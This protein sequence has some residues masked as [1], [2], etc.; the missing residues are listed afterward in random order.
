[1]EALDVLEGQHMWGMTKSVPLKSRSN[2]LL[3][4]YIT[5]IES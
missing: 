5:F 1:M 4:F 2:F 3:I